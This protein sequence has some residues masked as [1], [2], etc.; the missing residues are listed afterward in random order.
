MM[1]HDV[2]IKSVSCLIPGFGE[3]GAEFGE[4]I[5][6]REL[7]D[8]IT[9]LSS[10]GS[11]ADNSFIA[12]KVGIETVAATRTSAGIMRQMWANRERPAHA[13]RFAGYTNTCLYRMLAASIGRALYPLALAGRPPH[14]RA[15]IHIV[16]F[17][18]PMLEYELFRVRR[19]VGIDDV[20]LHTLIIQQGC[21]GLFSALKTAKLLLASSDFAADDVVLV[22]AENNMMP[23]LHQ[24]AAGYADF[25]DINSWLFPGI[26]G[27]G[28]GA[29]VLGRAG[30]RSGAEW[31]LGVIEDEMVQREWRI[32]PRWNESAGCSEVVT[33]SRAVKQTYLANVTNHATRAIAACGGP[34]AVFRL[35]L[36]ESNPLLV[37]TVAGRVGFPLDRVP[38]I[39]AS[40]GTLAIASSFSLLERATAD[41]HR[42]TPEQKQLVMVLIGES[43]GIRAGHLILSL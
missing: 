5:P 26:F 8:N 37:R 12:A 25:G 24:R 43:N 28:V 23:Y 27:E 30:E 20:D 1:S 29:L 7:L 41:L 11:R 4:L 15:H 10:H 31:R 21:A 33:R 19:E 9:S 22:T 13:A 6:T 39:S 18:Q 36:H 2:A 16:S 38:S 35:C 40:V 3:D 42:A 17:P 14:V 34:D 32:A